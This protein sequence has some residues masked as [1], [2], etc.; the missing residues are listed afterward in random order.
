MPPI[1]HVKAVPGTGEGSRCAG[2]VL[3]SLRLWIQRSLS[4]YSLHVHVSRAAWPNLYGQSHFGGQVAGLFAWR[5]RLGHF[6]SKCH[7]WLLS[8]LGKYTSAVKFLSET[9][10][11]DPYFM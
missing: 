2:L 8:H 7:W 6:A 11:A 5:A 4:L 10:A 1:G 3:F 9:T